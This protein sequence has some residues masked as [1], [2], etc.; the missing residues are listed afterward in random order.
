MPSLITNNIK[1]S[2]ESK[3]QPEHSSPSQQHFLYA[4]DIVV[5]NHGDQPV[6]LLSRIWFVTDSLAGTKEIEGAGVVGQCP[7]ILPGQSFTYQSWCPLISE[8]GRM[9]GL[10]YMQSMETL[11]RFEVIIPSFE[12]VAAPKL[13]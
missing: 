1:I 5:Q 8:I 4:Y 11:D 3:Y 13:N 2:A 7:V 6:K 10:F 12:L 9:E